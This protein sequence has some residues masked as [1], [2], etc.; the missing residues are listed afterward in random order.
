[1]SGGGMLSLDSPSIFKTPYKPLSYETELLKPRLF[2]FI[3][4]NP[5]R[6]RR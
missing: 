6:N 4:Y 3:D 5:F 1:L 2:D